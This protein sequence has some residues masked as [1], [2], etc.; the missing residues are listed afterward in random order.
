MILYNVTINIDKDVETEWL[1]WMKNEH[2]PQVLQSGCFIEHK[3][4]KLLVDEESGTTYAIQYFAAT[5]DK[6]KEYQQNYAAGLQADHS[7]RFKDKFAVFRTL[8]Q[9]V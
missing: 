4:F 6:V 7:M 2:I 5:M 8:L 9:M 1:N 3:I